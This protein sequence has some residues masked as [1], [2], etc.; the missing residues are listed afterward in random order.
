MADAVDP[1]VRHLQPVTTSRTY[2]LQVDPGRARHSAWYELFP[3]SA[4][5][6]PGRHGTLRDVEARL[7]DIAAMG[8]DVLYLPPV[9]PIGRTARKG[10]DHVSRAG[11]GDPGSPWAIGS[12]EGGHEAV[13]PELGTVE[14][15]ERLV[16]AAGRRGIDVALDLALQCSPDHPWV[17][18]HPEWFQH[19]PDGSIRHA[20]NPPKK[21]ED[22]VPIDFLCPDPDARRALW[23][24]VRDLV[25]LWIARGVRIFRVDNPHTKPFAFWEWLLADVRARHPDTLWLAE[26]FTRPKVMKHLAKLG[27]THSYTY[28]AWRDDV[29]GLRT[30]LEELTRS[31]MKEYFRP[32]LWPN[33]PDILTEYLQTGGRAAFQ[34]RLVLAATLAPNYGIYGPP[35]ERMEHEPWRPGSEEYRDSEK[36]QVRHW[37]PASDGLRGL[38]GRINRVRRHN[39]ALLQ[40]HGLVFHHVD[41]PHLLAYSK[42]TPGRDDAV[43]VVANLD[44]HHVHEGWTGLDLGALGI[45]PDE[46]FEVH[47][48]LTDARYPWRGP[49]NF[50]RLDPHHV[51]AHVLRVHRRTEHHT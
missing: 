10:A 23:E 19:L 42:R 20:E 45:T 41:D 18:E 37:P 21:Y 2:P 51:P 31:E 35:Y 16:Q 6:E 27:F 44:P 24:A 22:I 39:P 8:F 28:F 30:Y 43:L 9:H 46:P 14:D 38:V 5:P 49:R 48:L 25:E 12:G 36:F 1:H 26:A 29:H 33:T 3:R 7:D 11:P 40:E 50:V 34:V 17:H 15:L 4:S 13:H 47:D 32:H